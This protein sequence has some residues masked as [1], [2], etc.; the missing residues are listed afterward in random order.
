MQRPTVALSLHADASARSG[1]ASL[2]WYRDMTLEQ[3]RPISGRCATAAAVASVIFTF[4]R[5]VRLS[6]AP[7]IA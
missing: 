6:F 5:T 2:Q 3:H 1:N 4:M 7:R